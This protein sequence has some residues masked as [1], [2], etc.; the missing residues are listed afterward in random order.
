MNIISKIAI[1]AAGALALTAGTASAEIVCND[2]GDC[3]HVKSHID[4]PADV[5]VRVHSDDWRWK[6]NDHYRWREHAGRG[7][8]HSGA[9]V[10]I[11]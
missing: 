1:A 4:Y 10:D 8:W 3:W 2:D 9:W 11:R 7:Y 5:R 6:D